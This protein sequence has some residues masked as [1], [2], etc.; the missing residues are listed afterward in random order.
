ML[1]L[2]MQRRGIVL[3]ST[4]EDGVARVD[5]EVPLSEMFGFSTPLRSS[6]QGKA[7]FTME[8]AKYAETP[9]NI[10]EELLKK[11]AAAKEAA[12]K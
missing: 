10:T 9:S 3:G 5:A 12:R 2:I 7:E 6:T 8:F 1:G 11:A 4:E